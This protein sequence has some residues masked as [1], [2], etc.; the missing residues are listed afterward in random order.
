[1]SLNKFV[2]GA[3]KK[4]WMNINCE[5]VTC[6]DLTAD[7]IVLDDLEI[8][9]LRV[10]GDGTPQLVVGTETPTLE[11]KIAIA[12]GSFQSLVMVDDSTDAVGTIYSENVNNK[13]VIDPQTRVNVDV[14]API[15]FRKKAAV[16][17]PDTN[18]VA[19]YAKT[20]SDDIFIKNSSGAETNLTAG[21]T[22]ITVVNGT[23]NSLAILSGAANLTQLNDDKFSVVAKHVTVWGSYFIDVT[24]DPCVMTI[25]EVPG[26][27]IIESS[28]SGFSNGTKNLPGASSLQLLELSKPGAV[29]EINMV[30]VNDKVLVPANNVQTTIFFQIEYLTP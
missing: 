20:G 21:S 10:L 19:L 26:F 5:T 18:H 24:G 6:T 22:P 15:H 11:S 23:Y 28:L 14:E 8:T 7:N 13:F 3:D 29:V 25:S 9:T 27:P 1:M 16:G 2:N 12:G 30:T 17:N 4:E